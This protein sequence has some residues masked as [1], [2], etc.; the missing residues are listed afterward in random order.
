M[1]CSGT[2]LRESVSCCGWGS[3]CLAGRR[4][5]ELEGVGVTGRVPE[6]GLL[7]VRE[8]SLPPASLTSVHLS[9]RLPCPGRTL[10]MQF[11]LW[12]PWIRTQPTST[13]VTSSPPF[14]ETMKRAQNT[15]PS[16]SLACTKDPVPPHTRPSARSS[17]DCFLLPVLSSPPAPSR[18]PSLASGASGRQKGVSAHPCSPT[19]LG[20]KLGACSEGGAIMTMTIRVMNLYL[21]LPRA[22]G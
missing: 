15:A 19:Q 17:L 2:E 20:K 6:G 10:T 12:T 1:C 18:A 8:H 9:S 3:G 16:G 21:L 22:V 4:E 7:S 5:A 14:Q 11:C 13:R